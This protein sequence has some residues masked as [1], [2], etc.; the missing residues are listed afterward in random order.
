MINKI[1][2]LAE[3]LLSEGGGVD[4]EVSEPQT[5][6]IN[7]K[8]SELDDEDDEENEDK[9]EE[10]FN[11]KVKDGKVVTTVNKQKLENPIADLKNNANLMKARIKSNLP[12]AKLKRKISMLVRKRKIDHVQ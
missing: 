1:K 4:V 11:K 12:Q 3:A 7:K 8:K 9:S 5:Y 10:L 6:T 2:L